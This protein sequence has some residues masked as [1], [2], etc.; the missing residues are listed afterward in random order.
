VSKRSAKERA[1]RRRLR[2]RPGSY[3]YQRKRGIGA[4]G[5]KAREADRRLSRTPGTYRYNAAHG[6]G[7]PGQRKR[8]SQLVWSTRRQ[9]E[10]NPELQPM[11]REIEGIL[12][13]RGYRAMAKRKA[14]G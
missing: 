12:K 7:K 6:I 3:E 11:M 5:A 13:R 1:Y 2:Q 8:L 10:R 9:V 14:T 4:P